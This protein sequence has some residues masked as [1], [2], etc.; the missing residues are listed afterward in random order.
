[1]HLKKMLMF[2]PLIGAAAFLACG[3]D[4][5]NT[6]TSTSGTPSV[7]AS[8]GTSSSSS[9]TS[10]S[11]SG[12]ACNPDAS[13]IP[14][15]E[16]VLAFSAREVLAIAVA[17]NE[18][19]IDGGNTASSKATTPAV[20]Q[21][22]DTMVTDH[23]AALQRLRALMNDADASDASDAGDAGDADEAGDAGDT[24]DAGDAG[25]L[26]DAGATNDPTARAMMEEH[27]AVASL[28]ATK[29]G[30]D[31]DLAFMT[32]MVGDH[33]K[34]L[35]LLDRTLIPSAL[36]ANDAA[37]VT[38]LRAMRTAV[39]SHLVLALQVHQQVRQAM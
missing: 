3:G 21:F 31:F 6:N 10:S 12:G 11:S 26:G 13:G 9:S 35:S 32:S 25:D 1:M 37:L 8:C 15:D 16:T 28:L 24:G 34:I 22:A 19:E 2:A 30:L 36:A 14:A 39:V 20:K 29:S 23:A 4:D 33:A 38:E 18:G 7:D 17:A 27:E 5:D